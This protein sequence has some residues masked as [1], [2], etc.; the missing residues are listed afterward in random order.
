MW[1]DFFRVLMRWRRLS[2]RETARWATHSDPVM[3]S[4]GGCASRRGDP[5]D[6]DTP[7]LRATVASLAVASWAGM[8]TVW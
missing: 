5:D 4:K 8:E 3:G 1:V 6:S 2:I 7:E